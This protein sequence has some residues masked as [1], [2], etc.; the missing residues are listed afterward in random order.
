MI[1]KKIVVAYFKLFIPAHA[2]K[3]WEKKK[4]KKK[5]KKT[6]QFL[7]FRSTFES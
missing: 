4:K 2:W 6:I 1:W 7:V 5:T 3:E